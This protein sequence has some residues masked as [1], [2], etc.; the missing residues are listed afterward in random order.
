MLLK[1]P[2]SQRI[3]S[4]AEMEE[5]VSYKDDMNIVN[6]AAL[7]SLCRISEDVLQSL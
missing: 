4:R 2:S 6:L 5:A 1:L 7:S 3:H